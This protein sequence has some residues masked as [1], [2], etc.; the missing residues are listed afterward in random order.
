MIN[1]LAKLAKKQA[2]F[3]FI[4]Y[5]FNACLERTRADFYFITIFDTFLAEIVLNWELV[6]AVLPALVPL[7]L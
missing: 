5:S 3:G 4:E 7:L 1:G 6:T 2:G